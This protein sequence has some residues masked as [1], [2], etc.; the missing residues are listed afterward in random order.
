MVAIEA[1]GIFYM[2][3]A[4]GTSLGNVR[5]G[6]W[7][8]GSPVSIESE[9][10][11]AIIG[12]TGSGKT[13]VLL[14]IIMSHIDAGH[15]VTVIDPTGDLVDRVACLVPPNR[16]RDVIWFDPLAPKVIGLN[17]FE[18]DDKPRRLEQ[19]VNIV[20][21]IWP[22][23][24]GPQ[25]DYIA[26]NVG[27]AMIEVVKNPTLLH[28]VKFFYSPTYGDWLFQRVKSENL[29]GFYRKYKEDWDKRQR[30]QA[31]APPTNKFDSFLKPA[32]KLV[33]GQE[34]GL[35]VKR[36]IDDSKILL[37]RFD[38]GQLGPDAGAF[39][40]SILVSMLLFAA[41]ERSKQR[42]RPFH[43]VAVDEAHNFTR[44][45]AMDYLLAETRKYNEFLIL[46]D[47]L[48]YTK[49]VYG[50]V[51]NLIVGRTGAEDAEALAKEIGIERPGFISDL[52]N[53]NWLLKRVGCDAVH[54]AAYPPPHIEHGP[55]KVI[56]RSMENYGEVRE[57]VDRKIN[58]FLAS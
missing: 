18:G 20:S 15:G 31:A 50:N 55:D 34:R 23:A 27:L 3:I 57:D 25:S 33:V 17:P 48:G 12:A 45:N 53:R 56:R 19:A 9:G 26:R 47:Q 32:I 6:P 24:W 58:K 30:E 37:C 2:R 29:K 13:T 4:I 41:L 43:L 8:M 54:V 5:G 38:K 46:G 40:S 51:M 44:G 49:A 28:V 39:L 16:E 7:G 1:E 22:D 52:P 14:R 42:E 11:T 21:T 10:H 36:M 35:N